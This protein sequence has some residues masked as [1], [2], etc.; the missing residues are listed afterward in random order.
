MK[1]SEG[2]LETIQLGKQY[3]W[4]FDVAEELGLFEKL[5]KDLCAQG[6]RGREGGKAEKVNR[7]KSYSAL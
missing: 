2:E 5:W 6:G 3:E 7:V 4:K 1:C